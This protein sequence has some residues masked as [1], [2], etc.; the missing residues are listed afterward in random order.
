MPSPTPAKWNGPQ[1][2]RNRSWD[3]FKIGETIIATANPASSPTTSHGN[4]QRRL[5]AVMELA[6]EF[7]LPPIRLLK[8]GHDGSLSTL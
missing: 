3:V 8:V 2:I 4:R 7:C 5:G 1:V 6:I